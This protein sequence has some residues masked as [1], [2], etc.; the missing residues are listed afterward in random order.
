M[1]DNSPSFLAWFSLTALCGLLTVPFLIPY[2]YT[3]IPTFFQEWAAFAFG[4][5]ASVVLPKREL[6]SDLTIPKITVLPLLLISLVLVQYGLGLN[7]STSRALLFALYLIWSLMLM[8]ASHALQRLIEKDKIVIFLAWALVIGSVF[9]AIILLLQ[10][11]DIGTDVGVVASVGRSGGNLAQRNHLAD[12]LWLG[13]ASTLLLHRKQHLNKTSAFLALTFLAICSSLTGSRS[14]VLYGLLLIAL[15]HWASSRFNDRSFLQIR[16]IVAAVFC[17]TAFIQWSF[18]QSGVATALDMQ[19]SAGRIFGEIPGNSLRLQLWHTGLSIFSEHPWLGA[20]VGYFPYY[21]YIA[22]GGHN[23]GTYIGGGEHAHNLF[24][25]L[26]CEFGVAA[27]LIVLLAVW[28][29]WRSFI[30]TRWTC[31]QWWVAAMLLILGAHSQ[32]EY[33]LWYSFFLGIASLAFALGD[34]RTF[35]LRISTAPLYQLLTGLILALGYIALSS[36]FLDYRRLENILRTKPDGDSVAALSRIDELSHLRRESLFEDYV[37]LTFAHILD[38]NREA[39]QDKIIICKLA[40]QFSPVNAVVFKLAWLHA[41]NG[42]QNE[43]ILALQRA[44]ATHPAYIPTARKELVTLIDKFPE[45][46]W[47]DTEFEHLTAQARR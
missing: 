11:L 22:V 38:V 39:L 27:P 41:L 9:S 18:I 17:L 35:T 34:N 5:V 2:H 12:Y 32:L 33:P 4:L 14:A 47:L 42:D 20:G 13:I 25:Q 15:S 6:F 46:N 23:D 36:T 1:S 37:P 19:T 7:Q 43:S 28:F 45:I 40:I 3:P 8:I 31:T 29:W 21:S 16:N 30:G 10:L 24:I 44:M 26:L